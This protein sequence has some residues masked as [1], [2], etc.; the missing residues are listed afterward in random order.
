M[1]RKDY[2]LLADRIKF[3][4]VVAATDKRGADALKRL[5]EALAHDLE[6][7]NPRFDRDKF[8][9]ACGVTT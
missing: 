7:D 3:Q 5:A 8:I 6:A 9:K 2:R 1:T 4:Y